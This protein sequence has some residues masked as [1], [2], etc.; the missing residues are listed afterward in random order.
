MLILDLGLKAVWLTDWLNIFIIVLGL[1]VFDLH[2]DLG[3]E[4][5]SQAPPL[6]RLNPRACGACPHCLQPIPTF[7]CIA[8][9]HCPMGFIMGFS[10]PRP[11]RLYTVLQMLYVVRGLQQCADAKP[12]LPALSD[13]CT[14]FL[15]N[16]H[17]DARVFLCSF[18]PFFHYLL[19]GSVRQIT[20]TYVGFW[21]HVNSIS[22]RVQ[23][24]C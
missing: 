12:R 17:A 18:F 16:A 23:N 19:V 9:H 1:V 20:L 14:R 7:I 3:F 10:P 2:L 22:Y 21:A 6:R 15:S 24:S 13:C 4:A 11:V 5:A 8:L